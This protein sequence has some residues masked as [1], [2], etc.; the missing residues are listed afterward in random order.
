M[1]NHASWGIVGSCHRR[2]EH[3]KW[4][5]AFNGMAFVGKLQRLPWWQ[6]KV[7]VEQNCLL[8]WCLLGRLCFNVLFL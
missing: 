3:I 1:V 7:L 4:K 2:L 5:L 8:Q 6:V